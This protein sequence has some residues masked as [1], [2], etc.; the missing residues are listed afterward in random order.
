MAEIFVY[1]V[2]RDVCTADH[3]KS[4]DEEIGDRVKRTGCG[5]TG[6]SEWETEPAIQ[7]E[8]KFSDGLTFQVAVSR[9]SVF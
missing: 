1:D 6:T 4:V 5:K 3:R 9:S 2:I 8:F 7:F